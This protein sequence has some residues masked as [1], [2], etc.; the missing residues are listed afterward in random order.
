MRI[1]VQ[2]VNEASIAV[3][4]DLGTLDPTFDVQQI[5]LGLLL[6]VEIEPDDDEPTI[7]MMAN[8]VL[9]LRCFDGP[10]GS[11]PQSV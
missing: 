5:G 7:D 2:R 9:T 4:N 10:Q 11:L 8:R 6:T 1:S 3:L